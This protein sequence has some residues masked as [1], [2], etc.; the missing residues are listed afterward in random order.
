MAKLVVV[1]GDVVVRL[2]LLEKLGAMRGDIRLPLRDIRAV[3]I[4]AE[5]APFD[6]LVVSCASA[7]GAARR[8]SQ[9]LPNRS[10]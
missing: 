2:S 7:S 1:G 4:E 5:G 6:R 8:I 10:G 9:A 3:V